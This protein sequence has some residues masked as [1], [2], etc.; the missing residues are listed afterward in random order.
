[1]S[2]P[3]VSFDGDNYTISLFRCDATGLI[4]EEKLMFGEHILEVCAAPPNELHMWD[5]AKINGPSAEDGL[6][7]YLRALPDDLRSPSVYWIKNKEEAIALRKAMREAE[8]NPYKE[9]KRDE[10]REDLRL[11]LTW[12]YR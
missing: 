4:K 3:T 8:K 6:L 10:M 9:T 5:R 11:A 12:H 2:S 7:Y 1:M